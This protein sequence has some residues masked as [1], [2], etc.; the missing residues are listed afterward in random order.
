MQLG[1]QKEGDIFRLVFT[2]DKGSIAL[3]RR[4]PDKH[5]AM[6]TRERYLQ[7]GNHDNLRARVASARG[8]T[9]RVRTTENVLVT[10]EA[11]NG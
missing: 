11:A 2:D 9:K 4:H 8:E 6:R 1:I 3:G 5:S 7:P 10:K